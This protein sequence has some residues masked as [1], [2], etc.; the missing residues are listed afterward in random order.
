MFFIKVPKLITKDRLKSYIKIISEELNKNFG[1]K[2][3]K[4]N[5]CGLNPHAGEKVI[6]ARRKKYHYSSNQRNA[7]ERL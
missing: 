6:L 4:I 3:P 5:V 1:I 7:K 2:K